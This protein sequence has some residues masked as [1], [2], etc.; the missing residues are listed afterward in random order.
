MGREGR[1]RGVGEGIGGGMRRQ[2]GGGDTPLEGYVLEVTICV[3][4]I[5]TLVL[6]QS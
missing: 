4:T 3:A 2:G 6:G 1:K 5:V